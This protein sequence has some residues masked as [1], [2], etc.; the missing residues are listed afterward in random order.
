MKD[1]A[2]DPASLDRLHDIVV[3]EPVSWWPLAPGWYVLGGLLVF[4]FAV[5]IWSI[6]DRR[7][8]NRYR[9][10]GLRELAELEALPNESQTLPR[11]AALVKRVALAAFPREQVASLAGADW[12]TF[13]DS[14]AATKDFTS[15]PGAMLEAGYE[16]NPQPPS[17]DL[18]RVVRHWIGHHQAN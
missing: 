4:L 16:R 11:L 10:A 17:P 12:L 13:L 8:T 5:F 7:L 14:K 3:P 15:G 9:R 18:F 6:V 1:L 2:Q